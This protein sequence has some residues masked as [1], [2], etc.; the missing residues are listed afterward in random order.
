LALA[1]EFAR[2]WDWTGQHDVLRSQLE[3]L[4]GE[5]GSVRPERAAEAAGWLAFSYGGSSQ[6]RADRYLAMAHDAAEG[7]PLALGRVLAVESVVRRRRDADRALSAGDE[8]VRLLVRHGRLDEAAYAH[9]VAAISALEAGY[10][11]A[12]ASH[13]EKANDIYREI[14]DRRGM[15]WVD[16]ITARLHAVDAR[17]AAEFTER[18]KEQT[19]KKMLAD[20]A[21]TRDPSS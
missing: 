6:K 16:V 11:T 1:L 12:A 14:G 9:V 3:K 5:A 10:R 2:Y 17:A 8:A 21:G 7:D 15:A 13:V 18:F 19:T 20:A 4:L